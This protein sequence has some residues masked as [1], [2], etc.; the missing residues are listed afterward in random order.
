MPL[1]QP[2][3]FAPVR[4]ADIPR[5]T[6]GRR[7]V[8]HWQLTVA[9]FVDSGHEAARLDIGQHPPAN[10][11]TAVA[12]ALRSMNMNDLAGVARRGDDVYLYRKGG[13]A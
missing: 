4:V 1:A 12:Y 10:V 6:G 7:F 8:G 9:L 13:D 5:P 3:A 2:H 11:C